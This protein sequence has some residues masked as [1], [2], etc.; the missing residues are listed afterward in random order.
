MPPT[1][2]RPLSCILLS[3]STT[4]LTQDNLLRLVECTSRDRGLIQLNQ[5]CATYG[6]THDV[7]LTFDDIDQGIDISSLL[8]LYDDVIPRPENIRALVL[9][10]KTFYDYDIEQI[11]SFFSDIQEVS[12]ALMTCV[13]LN[14]ILA[15]AKTPSHLVDL[16][17]TDPD[18]FTSAVIN[19]HYDY[20]SPNAQ[21]LD[22]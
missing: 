18:K 9:F 5:L 10:A 13:N 16:A 2:L 20:F 14:R 1:A 17:E 21:N 11:N 8:A 22:L 3:R 7:G 19:E 15:N 12:G 6:N 4:T